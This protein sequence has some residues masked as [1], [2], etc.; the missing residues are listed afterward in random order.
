MKKL[1]KK[2]APK[3]ANQVTMP[4]PYRE[5]KS[6]RITQ[7]ENGFT[8]CT[9]GPKGEELKVAKTEAEALRHAKELLKG[10]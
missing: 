5:N 6:V 9:Y 3:K 8:V 1:V 7:A 4:Q 10:K 2:S